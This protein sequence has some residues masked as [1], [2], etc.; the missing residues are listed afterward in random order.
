MNKLLK[1][2]EFY[3]AL[4][5]IFLCIIITI[6]NP[7]FLTTENIFDLLKSF[8]VIGI[9]AVGVLFVLILSGSPDVS[10]TAIAQVVEY[11][12]VIMTLKWGGNIVFAFLVAAALGTLMGSFNGIL[13]HYFV[14][15]EFA[16]FL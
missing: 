15:C 13:V 10:F 1:Q 11:V 5:I 8:S 12:I 9:M 2:T 3:I 16:R 7:R 4:V 6:F 14:L